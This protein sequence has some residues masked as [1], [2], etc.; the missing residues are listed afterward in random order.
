M[1]LE[2]LFF[3]APLRTKILFLPCS[4]GMSHCVFLESN[5]TLLMLL[6]TLFF[7]APLRIAS[8]AETRPTKKIRPMKKIRAKYFPKDYNIESFML[9]VLDSISM[10]FQQT[11]ENI[12]SIKYNTLRNKVDLYN[13]LTGPKIKSQYFFLDI[14]HITM[15]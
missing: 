8:I 10:A 9:A 15:D 7:L 12:F 6:E 3:L 5:F 4:S 2:T 14:A 11:H 13:A 1:L